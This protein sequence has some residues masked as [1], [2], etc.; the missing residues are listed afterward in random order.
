METI[1][2]T[3][4]GLELADDSGLYPAVRTSLSL[5]LERIAI[6]SADRLRSAAGLIADVEHVAAALLHCG[7]ERGDRVAILGRTGFDWV[8]IDLATVAIGAV[9]VPI[10]PTSSAAQIAHIVADS[11]ARAFFGESGDD[12]DRLRDAGAG[13][14]WSFAETRT[15]TP[16]P[17]QGLTERVNAVRADDV[18]MI[19]YTSG[20]TGL[21]KGCKITHRNMYA[22]A[23]NTVQ[24]TEGMFKGTTALGLP[25]SHVFGQTILFACLLGGSDTH[26][27]PGIPDLIGAL[28]EAQPDFLTL[29]PY[30]LEK[31]RKADTN[32]E[33]AQRWGGR[34][35]NV[36]SG[37]ASLDEF[38]ARYF[39]EHGVCILN[40]YGM[41]EAA[42]AVT[43]SA[44]STNRIGTVGRPIPGTE[45][46]IADDS[47]ILVR[48]ANVTPGYWGAAAEQVM[49]DEEG[50]LHTGDLGRLDPDGFLQITGRRKEILVTTGGKNV[51][52]TLLEDRVR[53]HPLV[54]NCIVI[55]DGKP[56]VAALITLDPNTFA[57][58]QRERRDGQ[59][60]GGEV[61]GQRLR[62]ELSAAVDEANS[63]VS[64]A[65]SIREF[66]V[67]PR[68]FTVA[69]GELTSSLKLKRAAIIAA[70]AA[71]V[72]DIYRAA[73]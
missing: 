5:D 25:L 37:G 27:F 64:K 32:G 14:V 44:P 72:A 10:Y 17:D 11:G 63:L 45:V 33:G 6:R 60:D 31:M 51:A 20:T 15:W 65:E 4:P 34:L 67:L 30:A 42:T 16:A 71:I 39:A 35:R 55:G 22:S 52:P 66:R 23:A 57:D 69:T 48:G 50:W 7:V 9:V 41:T 19:V 38:T 53:L 43:V 40:C 59:T 26:L 18:A 62:D 61:D 36:I 49:V 8:V 13:D 47:E 24:Q 46:A 3:G 68:D 54:S 70:N 1:S 21:P 56:F 28:R 12:R 2:F 58:W 73:R 29:V